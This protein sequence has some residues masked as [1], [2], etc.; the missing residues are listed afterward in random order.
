MNCV[1][2]KTL[3]AL[4]RE[5]ITSTL[6]HCETPIY[7]QMK[8]EDQPP[9]SNELGCFVT[10]H[11]KEGTLRGCI[12]NLWGRGPLWQEVPKLARESAFSDPRFHPLRA[13]ELEQVVLEISLLS[14]LQSI[15]DWKQIRIGID[16]VL[17][18][19]G[20]H[21][22]VFLPQVATEQGWDL[23]TML[24]QLAM[25]AG[26]D[27]EAYTDQACRFEVFQAQVYKEDVS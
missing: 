1:E 20:Y 23:E 19:H 5:A 15:D 26:L 18:S 13:E 8:R 24:S 3:L 11:T 21:R 22:S 2:Q 12:G 9:Y 16:G 6:T 27:P 7:D 4:A 17:L 25:K 14:K 10:I